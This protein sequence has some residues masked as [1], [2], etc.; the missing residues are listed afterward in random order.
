GGGGWGGAG[1]Y[2]GLFRKVQD[3]G[4]E[5]KLEALEKLG[6]LDFDRRRRLERIILRDERRRSDLLALLERTPDPT[7]KEIR[8]ALGLVRKNPKKVRPS[9]KAQA[10]DRR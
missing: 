6:S 5:A 7:R 8:Q 9:T 4:I 2:E 10:G 1:Y 3:Q